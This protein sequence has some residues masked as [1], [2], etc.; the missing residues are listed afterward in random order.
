MSGLAFFHTLGWFE[1]CHLDHQPVIQLPALLA[2]V[3]RVG[4]LMIDVLSRHVVYV[5]QLHQRKTP[6]SCAKVMTT[7]PFL[8]PFST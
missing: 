5:P 2:V 1:T 8:C 4:V 3:I 7:F 6:Q